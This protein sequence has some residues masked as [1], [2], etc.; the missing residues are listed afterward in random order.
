MSDRDKPSIMHYGLRKAYS[1]CPLNIYRPPLLLPCTRSRSLK[2]MRSPKRPGLQ[3]PKVSDGARRYGPLVEEI[4]PL[5]TYTS[6]F[7]IAYKYDSSTVVSLVW[8]EIQPARPSWRRV[9]RGASSGS[10]LC[11]PF[12]RSPL[13]PWKLFDSLLDCYCAMVLQCPEL[14]C[15]AEFEGIL[16]SLCSFVKTL[17]FLSV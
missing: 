7:F 1:T 14:S 6:H 3:H 17:L 15:F 11:L 5:C 4:C 9:E 8:A 13:L 10:T 12:I 2:A 16:E